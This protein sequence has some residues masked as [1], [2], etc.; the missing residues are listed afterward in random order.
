[1]IYYITVISWNMQL[2]QDLFYTVIHPRLL[3]SIYPIK[4]GLVNIT[5]IYPW[6]TIS[7][8]FIYF[9]NK[10]LKI[11]FNIWT[12]T[13]FFHV[14]LIIHKIHFV[15][16]QL[17]HMKLSYLLLEIKLVLIYC[18]MKILQFLVPLIQYQID[19]LVINLRH[20]LRNMCGYL[21]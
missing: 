10:I 8:P 5:L 11:F 3:L 13:T 17:S 15:I 1:M 18:M 6:K 19:Q 20:S 9:F 2:L 12:C 4:L 21:L 14:K 16:Q 7:L